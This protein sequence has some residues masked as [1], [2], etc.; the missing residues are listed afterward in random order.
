MKEIKLI[1]AESG[2][3]IDIW[4]SLKLKEY[5]RN[6]INNLIENKLLLV[7]KKDIKPSYKIK[8]NDE[9]LVNIPE[10]QLLNI[11]SE[12]INIPILYEDDDII[13]VDK[14]KGMVVHPAAGNYSG[15]LVNALL[16]HCKD[17]LSNI[18][19]IIRPGIVHR[20]DKFTSGI[21]VVAKNNNAHEKLS[22]LFKAHDIKRVY[23]A[24]VDGV[25][26]E[27]SGKI[28]APIGRH[29]NFRKKMAVTLYN[30][31]NAITYFKVLKR[32][33]N[34]TYIEVTLETGRTHQIRTHMSYIGFPLIGDTEYG[35]KRQKYGIEG[36]ALHAKIL[37]FV[38]PRTNEYI[39]FEVEPPNCFKKLLVDIN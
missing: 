31:K 28:D 16:A 13:V 14:P 6:Y 34:A 24:V 12:N 5:S 26:R 19:G 37:G 25:I 2:I 17:G 29:S 1:S 11:V 39:E 27:E 9:I 8:V 38:H 23:I 10:P 15:T 21:I 3:R 36:Q 32:F 35:N 7:N 22:K 33:K 18:N 20:I 4:V 30:S